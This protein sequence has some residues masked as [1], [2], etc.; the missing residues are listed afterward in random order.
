MAAEIVC[1]SDGGT[2]LGVNTTCS[3][4]DCNTNGV[5]DACDIF[6][7]TSQ[8]CNLNEIPDDCELVDNDCNMN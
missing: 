5:D 3:E 1:S 4:N 7:G 8:D 6:I 2:F